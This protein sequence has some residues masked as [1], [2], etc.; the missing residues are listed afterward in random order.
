MQFKKI[1]KTISLK[2]RCEFGLY[3]RLNADGPSTNQTRCSYNKIRNEGRGLLITAHQSGSSLKRISEYE[4]I[5]Q[6]TV[7]KIINKYLETRRID[8]SDCGGFRHSKITDEIRSFIREKVDEYCTLTLNQI[9]HLV[10][11][12]FRITLD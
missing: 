11:T 12:Q 8:N 6:S 7:Q 1:K 4:H 2:T 3:S 10:S 5:P 9:A